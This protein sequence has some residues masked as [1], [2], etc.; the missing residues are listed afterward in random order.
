VPFLIFGVKKYR[1]PEIPV[2]GQSRYIESD[3]IR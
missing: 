3:T 2:K 1:D